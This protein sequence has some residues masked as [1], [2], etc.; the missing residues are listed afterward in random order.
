MKKATISRITVS[1]L[2]NLGNYENC[3]YSITVEVPAGASAA[4]AVRGVEK[5]L[6]GLKPIKSCETFT[7]EEE[8][9]ELKEI[10]TIRG[11]DKNQFFRHYG[12]P[13]GG[14]AAYI[15]RRL[16][17]VRD[18]KAAWIKRHAMAVKARELFDDLG[19]AEKWKDAKNDWSDYD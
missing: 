8:V 18:K 13:E 15:K 7:A 19:G 3:S 5:I 1:R 6:A 2:Y 16:E 14:K 9:R 10:Q 12:S 17:A 4:R 11:M